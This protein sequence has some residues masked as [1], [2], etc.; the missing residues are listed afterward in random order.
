M[1]PEIAQ[2]NQTNPIFSPFIRLKRTFEVR[3]CIHVTALPRNPPRCSAQNPT[4]DSLRTTQAQI[5]ILKHTTPMLHEHRWRHLH[6]IESI[7][8]STSTNPLICSP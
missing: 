8:C 4:I 5:D 2:K 7:M 1:T 6:A 3:F